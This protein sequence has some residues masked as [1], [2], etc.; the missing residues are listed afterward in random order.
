MREILSL[1]KVVYSGATTRA[2]SS[3]TLLAEVMAA[4]KATIIDKYTKEHEAM[5]LNGTLVNNER[6]KLR[7]H[8]GI[9]L[10]IGGKVLTRSFRKCTVTGQVKI[11]W[12]SIRG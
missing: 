1:W 12:L 7:S 11:E 3:L 10:I 8:V 4:K 6:T 9:N 5:G 2:L